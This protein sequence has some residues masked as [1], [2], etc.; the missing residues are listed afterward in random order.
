MTSWD[1]L[2][3]GERRRSEGFNLQALGVGLMIYEDREI[4][5]WEFLDLDKGELINLSRYCF[6]VVFVTSCLVFIVT[7]ML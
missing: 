3:A 4:W 2:S 5:T 7:N 6:N 1:F